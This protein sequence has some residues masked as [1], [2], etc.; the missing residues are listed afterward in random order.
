[1]PPDCS[2]ENSRICSCH[3][4]GGTKSAAPSVFEWSERKLSRLTSPPRTHLKEEPEQKDIMSESPG[5]AASL[6]PA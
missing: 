1:R 6:S 3:F 5:S 2:N 4:V